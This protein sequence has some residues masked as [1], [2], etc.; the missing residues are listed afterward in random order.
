MTV[1]I[2]HG[3]CFEELRKLPDAS[4]DAI[5]TD[6]PYGIGFMGREW[7]TFKPSIIAAREKSITR[8]GTRRRSEKYGNKV[9]QGTQGGGVAIE[10]A[11]DGV[12]HR[13]FQDWCL[14]WGLE[15][16]RILKPGGHLLAFG[17]PRAHH[18]LACGIEDAGLEIRDSI[19]WIFGS[20][21]PKST[22]VGK[23]LDK[24]V[25]VLGMM[26]S[27][28]AHLREWKDRAG[29]SNRQVN[30]AVGSATSGAGMAGHW[31]GE[32]QPEAP[33]KDQWLKLK[34][35]LGWP[36]CELDELYA[37]L[38]D[39]HERPVIGQYD[40][41]A[42]GAQWRTNVE[43]ATLS[44]PGARTV[45]ASEAAAAWDGW[46]TALKPAYEPIVVA[47]KPLVGSI[48]ANVLEHGTGGLNVAATRVDGDAGRWPTNLVLSHAPDCV[49]GG[50]CTRFCPVQELDRQS[51]VLTSGLLPAGQQRRAS[52]GRGGYAGDFP[53]TAALRDFGGDSGGASRFFPVFR[54]EAKPSRQE[55]GR[56][57]RHPTV[58][59]IA[60]MA[61]LVRLVVAEGG[62]VLDPFLGSGTTAIACARAGV[63][64]IGIEREAEYVETARR[65]VAAD[66]PLFTPAAEPARPKRAEPSLFSDPAT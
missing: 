56:G 17:S 2:L 14:A 34:A 35:V 7:D 16:R 9:G 47:R 20:G 33:S 44:A 6:P 64:C 48:A 4:V 31:F 39:G 13:A 8:K 63:D 42:P 18:R 22:D 51:G 53:D 40:R 57:N 58:K 27:I 52:K 50:N 28:R 41:A 36:D 38:K 54:Y 24:S 25:R 55:R 32:S 10:Y 46:G 37:S 26:G 60:L 11:E 45:P 59:P 61:W 5:V 62:T 65:R 3:D 23:A 19:H 30:Q 66:A 29:L 1:R 43:A 12:G 21:F 49:D 15:A